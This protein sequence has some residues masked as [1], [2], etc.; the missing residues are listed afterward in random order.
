MLWLLLLLRFMIYR[1]E[2][3]LRRAV[4]AK[5]SSW[6]PQ[7]RIGHYGYEELFT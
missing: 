2:V 1:A 5:E 6:S 7:R 4:S 3:D